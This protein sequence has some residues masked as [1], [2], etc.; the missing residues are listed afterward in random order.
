MGTV[1]KAEDGD[2]G[3]G[4]SGEEEEE[5]EEEGEEER[6][7]RSAVFEAGEKS[8]HGR[9]LMTWPIM[10]RPDHVN[11]RVVMRC[12]HKPGFVG[13]CRHL[14]SCHRRSHQGQPSPGS[15]WFKR[16]SRG[17]P[18][19][20]R[21]AKVRSFWLSTAPVC[22]WDFRQRGCEVYGVWI[23]CVRWFQA[24]QCL[25]NALKAVVFGVVFSDVVMS[26]ESEL[27]KQGSTTDQ[28]I[29]ENLTNVQEKNQKGAKVMESTPTVEQNVE[30]DSTLVE[31][32]AIMMETEVKKK[33]SMTEIADQIDNKDL[34]NVEE[35][36]TQDKTVESSPAAEQVVVTNLLLLM[37]K[38]I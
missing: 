15:P 31:E 18:L 28:V 37:N 9:A 17:H 7:R 30:A 33:D 29:S 16:S 26:A 8:L 27:E 2:G 13:R 21:V 4:G 38:Q 10:E 34:A 5:E 22:G 25:G 20:R 24:V 14:L 23:G 3:V 19:S 12:N 11:P 32:L 1:A 35:E 36:Q 6:G